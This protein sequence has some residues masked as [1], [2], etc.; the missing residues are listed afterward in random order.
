MWPKSLQ[1]QL[2]MSDV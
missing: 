2:T 1:Q